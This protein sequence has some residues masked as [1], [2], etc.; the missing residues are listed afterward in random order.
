[1]VFGRRPDISDVQEFGIVCWVLLPHQ[2]QSKLTP[3]SIQYRFVGLNENGTGYRYYVPT[4]RQ[5]LISRNIIFPRHPTLPSP[6]PTAP[7]IST[8]SSIIDISSTPPSQLEGDTVQDDTANE[9]KP[10]K[11]EN[12]LSSS[13]DSDHRSMRQRKS[14]NYSSLDNF[15]ISSSSN[16]SQTVDQ[17]HLQVSKSDKPQS[18]AEVQARSD[19]PKWQE[20]MKT[21]LDQLSK[22]GTYQL[23]D[24]PANRKSIGCRWVFLIKRDADGNISKYKARLVAQGFSQV[25]GQDF[26]ATYAP[27]M[28]LESFRTIL[29]I[30]ASLDLE[31][32]Q[33]DVVGAYLNSE[34]EE[35]IY[36][37]QPPG[38]DDNSGRV[39]RLLKA[40]YGLKQ[41][42]RAWN[43]KLN[44]I[45]VFVLNF[46]RL[47]ADFCV[48]VRRSGNALIIIVIHVDDMAICASNRTIMDALKKDL[49]QHL[50][51][52]DLGPIRFFLGL[53][54]ER[55]RSA[56]TILLHQSKYISTIV[57]RFNLSNAH[58]V[59]TPLDP[60]IRLIPSTTSNSSDFPYATAIG[61]LM[62]AA[63]STRPD[64]S[65]A[66]QTL[67]QFT[68]NFDNSHVTAVKHVLRYLKNTP[69]VGTTF[70]AN[71]ITVSGYSDADWGQNPVDRRSI[72]GYTFLVG[73]SL[74]SWSSKKQPT[75][76]LSS[77]EAEYIALAHAAKEAIWLR[78]LLN[79]LE[80]RQ[81]NPTIVH[82]DN[83]GAIAFA[84]DSQ[85]HTRSKHIDIRHHFIRDTISNGDISTV[86]V[87]S[88]SNCADLLTKPLARPSHSRALDLLGM[89]PN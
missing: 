85:F 66:V 20:A 17:I 62:Y 37:R 8:T 48:Y 59:S 42:G 27:V 60:S 77:M 67:S 86:Y 41:A 9:D 4:H 44:H 13:T 30:A 24:P 22:L 79:E 40:L 53:H 26:F 58:P 63:V 69:K 76:A 6:A 74:V 81:P 28:R 1:M 16:A 49:S 75:V 50:T 84:H 64:I 56:R 52:T 70:Y 80:F 68:S 18:L 14:I 23:V 12:S 72:S 46:T 32:D 21:K 38:F 51:I 33:V 89:S 3:K 88:E 73:K 36:M 47:H 87:P 55:N 45:L 65:Y 29:S 7:P 15:G 78:N 43:T 61:S 5:V 71:D 54:I 34:L 31:I 25:P 83:Q 35:D 39:A 57:D 19:W 11:T 10:K 2:Q 82:S